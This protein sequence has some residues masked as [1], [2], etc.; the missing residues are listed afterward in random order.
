[1]A[2]QEKEAYVALIAERDPKI[3]ALLDQGFEFFMNAFKVGA[4]PP[5]LK[6][7]TDRE[8]VRSLR[9]EGYQVEVTTAYDEQGQ[10]R[11]TLSAIWRK[12]G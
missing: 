5:G 10:P 4:A 1:M 7:K 3:R 11:P 12:R 6:T 8:Q 2:G 9:R